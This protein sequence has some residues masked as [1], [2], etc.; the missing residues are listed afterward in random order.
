MYLHF[1]TLWVVFYNQKTDLCSFVSKFCQKKR[2]FYGQA[3]RKEGGGAA[4]SAPTVSKCEN[5]GPMVKYVNLFEKITTPDSK[6]GGGGNPLRSAEKRPFFYD[7]PWAAKQILPIWCWEY[8]CK[9]SSQMLC[10]IAC[11]S[12][13]VHMKTF[14]HSE[15]NENIAFSHEIGIKSWNTNVSKPCLLNDESNSVGHLVRCKFHL[16]VAIHPLSLTWPSLFSIKFTYT[17]I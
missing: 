2:S 3:D 12:S 16:R 11:V 5:F 14:V 4:P 10:Q 8:V 7:F 9:P 15:K 1:H 17:Q 6:W 13:C